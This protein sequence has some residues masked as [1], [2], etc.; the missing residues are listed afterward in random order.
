VTER[1]ILFNDEMVRALLDGKKTQTRR[2]VRFRPGHGPGGSNC[3]LGQVI[4]NGAG[5]ESTIDTLGY[6]HYTGRYEWQ[7][8]EHGWCR[9]SKATSPDPFGQPGDRLWVREAFN[10]SWTERT[11]YRADGGSAKA[12]GYLSEPVW[13][14]SIH[15]PRRQSRITLG[16]K[17]VWAERVQEI[18]ESDAEA[19]GDPKRGLIASENTHRDWFRSAWDHIYAPKGRGWDANPWVFACEFEVSQ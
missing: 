11:I 18:S 8:S 14:P 19:E 16:V 6:C 4:D 9:C 12:A 3:S 2:P 5:I 17:R 15:M 7:T 1:P 10:P 13:T